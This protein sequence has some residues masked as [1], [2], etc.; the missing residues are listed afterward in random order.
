MDTIKR[1]I[2][3]GARMLCNAKHFVM[4]SASL[5]DVGF[6][7]HTFS[8]S[9]NLNWFKESSNYATATITI[10]NVTDFIMLF[11]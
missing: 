1:K 5:S 3:T 6:I 8:V 4:M 10:F 2:G 9:R 11:N 7:L